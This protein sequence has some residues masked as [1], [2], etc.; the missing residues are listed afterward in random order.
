MIR[1]VQAMQGIGSNALR[2]FK[3]NI[4]EQKSTEYQLY[5]FVIMYQS[6]FVEE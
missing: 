1:R 2:Y 6:Y 4:V 5:Q 3:E